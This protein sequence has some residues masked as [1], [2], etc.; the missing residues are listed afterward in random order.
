MLKHSSNRMKEVLII[1]LAI[2][3]VLSLTAVATSGFG[4]YGGYG[5][6]GITG[7]YGSNCG[8]VNS[9]LICSSY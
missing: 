2:L 8:V 7:D 6:V 1:S 4:G 9:A 5:S 3:F